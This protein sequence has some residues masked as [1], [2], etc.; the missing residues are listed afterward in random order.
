MEHFECIDRVFPP[1][2]VETETPVEYCIV[3]VSMLGKLN[4]IIQI[5]INVRKVVRKQSVYRLSLV[6]RGIKNLQ[7]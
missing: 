6:I 4:A 2:R 7:V 5:T 3:P 1:M